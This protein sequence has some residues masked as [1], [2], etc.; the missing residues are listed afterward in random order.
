MLFSCCCC[1]PRGYAGCNYSTRGHQGGTHKKNKTQNKTLAT[2]SLTRFKNASI[3]TIVAVLWRYP[4][5][6]KKR[7][8]TNLGDFRILLHWSLL[9]ASSPL[10]LALSFGTWIDKTAHLVG[11]LRSRFPWCNFS[12]TLNM[13]PGA[14]SGFA[15]AWPSLASLPPSSFPLQL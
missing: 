14:L 4:L 6:K 8:L 10:C 2:I 1:S 11:T 5:F 3:S 7:V 12:P 15:K 9:E 13:F